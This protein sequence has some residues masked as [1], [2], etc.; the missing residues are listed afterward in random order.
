MRTGCQDR[1]S[2]RLCQAV[3]LPCLF[4][5]ISSFPF[6]QS[7]LPLRLRSRSRS[8]F[9]RWR[10][11]AVAHCQQEKVSKEK[12]NLLRGELAKKIA[13]Q[14]GERARKSK[15]DDAGAKKKK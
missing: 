15:D 6:L 9:R 11:D 14:K 12:A 5:P 2:R 3:F 10:S 8:C 7:P 1:C 13:E 4:V